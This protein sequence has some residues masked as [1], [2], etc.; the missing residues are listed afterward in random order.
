MSNSKRS[1]HLENKR[2]KSDRRKKRIIKAEKLKLKSKRRYIKNSLE[3]ERYLA[4][5]PKEDRQP[6][7]KTLWQPNNTIINDKLSQVLNKEG[8]NKMAW[9]KDD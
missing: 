9:R 1:Q 8:F 6:F 5:M 2:K 4:A 7:S 3:E